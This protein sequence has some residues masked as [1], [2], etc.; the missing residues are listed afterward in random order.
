WVDCLSLNPLRNSPLTALKSF[1]GTD[2]IVTG[3]DCKW[4]CWYHPGMC[5]C[6]IL[7]LADP[8][9]GL[10][11]TEGNGNFTMGGYGQDQ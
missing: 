10:A 7:T 2:Q 8:R 4:Q 3:T 11:A 1:V 6:S 5:T 9:P